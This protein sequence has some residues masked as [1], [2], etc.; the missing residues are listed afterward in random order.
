MPQQRRSLS[1]LLSAFNEEVFIEE[2]VNSILEAFQGSTAAALFEIEVIVID[3][4]STDKTLDILTGLDHPSLRVL[5]N[6]QKGKVHA[7]NLALAESSGEF[8]ILF[9]GD[10]LFNVDSIVPRLSPMLD[11]EGPAATFC[12]LQAFRGR[13]DT[14]AQRFPRNGGGARAGG[15]IAMNRAF[16][17]RCLP[18]PASLPNEDS[19]LCLHADFLDTHVTN[20][21]VVGMWYRLHENNSSA[22]GSN[23]ADRQRAALLHR[24]HVYG[25]FQQKF[26]SQVPVKKKKRLA[27]EIAAHAMAASGNFVSILLLFGYPIKR[28]IRAMF[29]SKPLL[30][31]MRVRL[32]AKVSGLV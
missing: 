19:W 7:Y 6:V 13:L 23:D 29:L 2:A 30:W 17:E 10:D 32:G 22:Y 5:P 16:V 4:F 27:Q 12:A 20:V 14:L 3:D 8:V 11:V 21:D 28:R 24:S 1:I 25:L 26:A 31:R 9:A 18:I 15:A